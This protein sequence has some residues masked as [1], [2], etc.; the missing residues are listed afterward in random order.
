MVVS[1]IPVALRIFSSGGSIRALVRLVRVG[2]FQHGLQH[3]VNRR[4]RVN[5][6]CL[7]EAA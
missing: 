1:R 7:G 3:H 4:R 2:F 5:G 6:I